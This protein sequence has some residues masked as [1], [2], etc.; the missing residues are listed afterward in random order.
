MP[1][2][3]NRNWKYCRISSSAIQIESPTLEHKPI[4]LYCILLYAYIGYS[5]HKPNR[6]VKS[7]DKLSKCQTV[8][9]FY[10]LSYFAQFHKIGYSY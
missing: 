2:E 3:A 7:I 10:N 8:F 9:R 4:A 1:I 5:R 6:G